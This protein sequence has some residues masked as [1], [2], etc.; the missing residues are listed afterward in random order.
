MPAT[1]IL[2]IGTD[3]LESLCSTQDGILRSRTLSSDEIRITEQTWK[4]MWLSIA[5][6]FETT[7]AWSNKGHDKSMM[8]EFCR[9]SMDFADQVFDRYSIFASALSTASKEDKSEVEKNL[10]EAPAQAAI[11]IVKWLRLRDDYLIDKAVTLASSLMSRLEAVKMELPDDAIEFINSIVSDSVRS[12]LKSSQKAQLRRALEKHLGES[13]PEGDDVKV[14]KQSSLNKWVSGG[15]SVVPTSS[16]QKKQGIDMDAWKSAAAQ[17]K[18]TEENEH[19]KLVA[20]LTPGLEKFRAGG[21]YQSARPAGLPQ[22]A[23]PKVVDNE[24]FKRKRQAEMEARKKQ[25]AAII[26][27]RQKNRG[28]GD[29][30]SALANIGVE[31]RDYTTKGEGV[32]VSSDESSDDEG[33]LDNELFGGQPKTSKRKNAKID[34]SGVVGMKPEQKQGPVRIQRQMR[35]HKDM[36]ARLQPD[37]SPLH[38]AILSWEFFHQ[39]DYPPNSSD[40]QYSRVSNSFRHVQDYRNTFQPLLQLEAWQGFVGVREENSDNLKSF[41]I[42]VGNR[43]SVDAFVEISTNISY[44]ENKEQQVSEGDVILFSTSSTPT[45]DADAPH[46]LSRVYKINRKKGTM[47][48][49]YRVMPGNA[50][51]ASLTPNSVIHGT[52]IQSITPLEREYSALSGL[53][54]YDLCDEI[55]KAKPSPLLN[56]TD[57]QLEPLM[58]NYT[59]NKAQAKAIKSALDN[60]A[61]TLIQGPPGTG[62]TKTIVAIVGGL[63]SDS[64]ANQ[65][66]ATRIDVPKTTAKFQAPST[67]SKKLLVCAPSNAAVDELVMRLK[68]GVKTVKGVHKKINVLR[69]GR[70]DKL[71]SAVVDVTMDELVNKRMGK[72]EKD[73]NPREK[74]RALIEEHQKVNAELN[75]SLIH[76]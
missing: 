42:K 70:S 31:G 61:F 66:A 16:T 23:A 74:T 2:K 55:I 62:K 36:R 63:L 47:E 7:E 14:V 44:A 41:E 34:L 67:M 21:G 49:V 54:Y 53:Q 59:V 58:S 68:E 17:S 20:S 18:S 5:T 39:G 8:V 15:A 51:N 72:T 12:K 1:L 37:L 73:N 33:D 45:K 28:I 26:A 11:H 27:A 48:V 71:N 22:K 56:Y 43:S 40:W 29:A 19:R 10:L 69:L 60:D 64:L 75:L 30:G 38:K 32:M 3:F 52:K 35:S 50:L 9:D 4:M 6:I 57:K 76:I 13:E 25:N 46:C 24:E 65:S